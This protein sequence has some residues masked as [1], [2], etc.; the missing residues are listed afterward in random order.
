MASLFVCRDNSENENKEIIGLGQ[1]A[2]IVDANFLSSSLQDSGSS[3]DLQEIVRRSYPYR[4]WNHRK[5]GK[6]RVSEKIIFKANSPSR[7]FAA[8]EIDHILFYFANNTYDGSVRLSYNMRND[9]M[10]KP[11]YPDRS[12]DGANACKIELFHVNFAF[13]YIFLFWSIQRA[14]ATLPFGG[15]GDLY[16]GERQI[17]RSLLPQTAEGPQL[18]RLLLSEFL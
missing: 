18:C 3:R 13:V 10:D 5:R 16:K 8:Q 9:A 4:K 17:R 1:N 6:E 2:K 12:F 11:K 15:L 14:M 7:I